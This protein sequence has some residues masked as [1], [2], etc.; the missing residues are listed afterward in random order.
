MNSLFTTHYFHPPFLQM[1]LEPVILNPKLLDKCVL[2]VTLNWSHTNSI[3]SHPILSNSKV[4]Q[5]NL[6]QYGDGTQDL[7]YAKQVL[8]H[9]A[10]PLASE[11]IFSA[12]GPGYSYV[13]VH[14][15]KTLVG[16]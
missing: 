8:Y 15:Y 9:W 7:A 1:K 11:S 10:I 3:L 16:L 2:Q 13:L 5:E 6:L 4:K 14:V 12:N